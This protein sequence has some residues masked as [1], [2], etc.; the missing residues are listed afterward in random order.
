MDRQETLIIDEYASA[1]ETVRLHLFLAH[2]EFRDCFIRIEMEE[3]SIAAR[4]RAARP[5][6]GWLARIHASL[7][8]I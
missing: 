7:E 6:R 3:L 5:A 4:K 1:D 2:R 8:A